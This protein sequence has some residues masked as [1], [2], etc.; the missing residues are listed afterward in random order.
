MKLIFENGN[1][2]RGSSLFS[3]CDVPEVSFDA[4]LLRKEAPG[5]PEVSETEIDRHY[6]ALSQR[7]FGVC[8]GLY[9]LGSCTMKYN[10]AVNEEMAS[11]TA[12]VIFA[13]RYAA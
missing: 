1:A 3:K 8:D 9:P 13:R 2:G 12:A 6:F 11:I 10:P 7:T 4:S 5:L